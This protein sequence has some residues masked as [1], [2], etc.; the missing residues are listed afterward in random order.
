[1]K[2]ITLVLGVVAVFA[3]AVANAARAETISNAQNVPFSGSILNPCTGNTDTFTG[4]NHLISHLTI[5]GDRS[6]FQPNDIASDFKLVDATAG[7]CTGQASISQNIET[8]TSSLPLTTTSH[9]SM[10]FNCPGPD[11]NFNGSEDIHVTV[12]ADGTTTV[13]IDNLVLTCK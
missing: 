8:T 11:N 6:H 5:N 3:F 12:N 1:M 10:R 13:S 7:T 4:F 2:R 9:T